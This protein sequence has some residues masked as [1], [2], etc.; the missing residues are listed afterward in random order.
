MDKILTYASSE[1]MIY[2]WNR[3]SNVFVIWQEATGELPAYASITTH[4]PNSD[5]NFLLSN[6]YETDITAFR[7][8]LN[9]AINL[10]IKLS[11]DKTGGNYEIISTSAKEKLIEFLS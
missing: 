7:H 2:F 10:I 11:G 9:K 1:K 8:Y 6:G 3:S 5:R 4:I